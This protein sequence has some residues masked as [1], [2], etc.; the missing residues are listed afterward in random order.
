VVGLEAPEW[1][2]KGERVTP[3]E[4]I[5]AQPPIDGPLWTIVVPALLFGIALLATYLLYRHFAED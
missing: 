3:V 2:G 4:P 5:P 1:E